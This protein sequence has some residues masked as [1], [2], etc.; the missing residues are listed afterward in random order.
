LK[1]IILKWLNGEGEPILTVGP[2]KFFP[3]GGQRMGKRMFVLMSF[4]GF[5]FSPVPAFS[6]CTD[7]SLMTSWYVQGDQSIVFYRGNSP[8]AQ[9]DLQDC[10]V[11]SS[12][13]VRLIKTYVC[14]GDQIVIDGQECNIMTVTLA[15][16]SSQ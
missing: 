4:W 10:T 9:V 11:N 1:Y 13:N 14:D 5:L 7:L 16:T 15:S 2:A 8:L 12:S 3:T 6:D